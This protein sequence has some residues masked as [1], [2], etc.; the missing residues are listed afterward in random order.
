MPR[1]LLWLAPVAYMALIIGLSSIPGSVAE[2]PDAPLHWLPE[3]V[4]NLLHLPLYAGLAFVWC[5]TLHRLTRLTPRHVAAI[6]FGA[7]VV[8]GIADEL[9]QGLIPG[10]TPSV[11]DVVMN[12]LGAGIAIVLFPWLRGWLPRAVRR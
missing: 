11:S 5:V 8:F 12:T 1:A 10:R 3:L 4:S 2:G 9:Y 7:S 6:A